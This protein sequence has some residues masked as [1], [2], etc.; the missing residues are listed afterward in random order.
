MYQSQIVKIIAGKG[1]LTCSSA[2]P[3]KGTVLTFEYCTCVHTGYV[4]I[5]C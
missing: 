1:L 4:M 5:T 2:I 3:Q